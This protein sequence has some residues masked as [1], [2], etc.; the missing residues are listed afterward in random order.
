M[1]FLTA[2]AALSV[3]GLVGCQ[4]N[5]PETVEEAVE[6]TADDLEDAADDVEDAA[7]PS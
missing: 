7:D 4:D 6:Q 3:F 2:I 5:E 1:K